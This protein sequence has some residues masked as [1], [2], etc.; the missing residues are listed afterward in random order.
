MVDRLQK[1]LNRLSQREAQA[2]A[3]IMQTIELGSLVGLDVKKLKGRDDVF[4]VRFGKHRLILKKADDHW[5]ILAVERRTDN[6][7]R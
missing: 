6:T 1:N 7:Y 2:L 3:R 5:I 4:R